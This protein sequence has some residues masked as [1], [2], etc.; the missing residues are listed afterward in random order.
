MIIKGKKALVVIILLG[1]IA[2]FLV[3]LLIGWVLWPVQYYDTDVVDLKPEHR[4]DYVVMVGA[5]YVLDRDLEQAQARLDRLEVPDVARF[6]AD[7][8]ER[9]MAN[10]ADVADVYPLVALA[11]ALGV[12]NEDMLAYIATPTPTVTPTRTPIPSS[13]PSPTS[14][15]TVALIP[16][17][18]STPIPPPPT[19]V[20][21]SDTPEPPSPTPSPPPPT[22]TP[23]PGLDFG[24]AVQRIL[25]I[26][27]NGGCGG[28][29]ILT[30]LVVDKEAQPL[31]GVVMDV[32]WSGGS[33]QIISGAKE[34]GLVEFEMHGAYQV[35]VVGDISGREYT[36]QTTRW[37]DSQ[38]PP[39]QDLIA[40]EYCRDE[41]DCDQKR[42]QN[43]LC[44]GHYSYEVV[45]QRQW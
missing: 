31:D 17:A 41:Q 21:P 8:T 43:L 6:V 34:S 18:T 24:V 40:G 9:Y 37:L 2:G 14:T 10:G 22:E 5:A 12:S 33:N 26:H 39:T 20:P 3:G 44:P 36:G 29:R 4:D 30:V 42:Q 23:T 35:Q 25:T 28:N 19:P 32:S 16:T 11:Q 38:D 1:S 7:L 13:T 45:F 27:E 15:P